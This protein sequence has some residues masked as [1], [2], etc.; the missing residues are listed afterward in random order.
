[1]V[2]IYRQNFE[3]GYAKKK[4][5]KALFYHLINQPTD[6]ITLKPTFNEFVHGLIPPS[7]QTHSF[8]LKC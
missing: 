3:K 8:S 6:F 1:M 7:Q 5:L 2:C 4:G